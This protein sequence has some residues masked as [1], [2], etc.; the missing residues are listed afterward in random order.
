MANILVVCTANVCRSPVG[1]AVLRDRLHERGLKDWEVASAGTWASFGQ[2]ASYNSIDVLADQGLDIMEHRS[3]PVDR[4]LLEWADL[5]LCMELGHAEALRTEFPDL[6]DKI[7]TLS[8]MSGPGYSVYD[9]YG[10]PR[11]AYEAMVTEV[12]KL[13][14]NGLNQMVALAQDNEGH[15]KSSGSGD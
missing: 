10:E 8:E 15:R 9:P 7:F 4:E 14:D 5:T 12:T 2:L 13:V 3:R 11:P 6:A 1:E